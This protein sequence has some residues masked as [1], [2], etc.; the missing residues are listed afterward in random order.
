MRSRFEDLTKKI[1]QEFGEVSSKGS[2]VNVPSYLKPVSDKDEAKKQYW[3]VDKIRSDIRYLKLSVERRLSEIQ[4]LIKNPD[5]IRKLLTTSD[6]TFSEALGKGIIEAAFNVS[7][8]GVNWSIDARIKHATWEL[9][10]LYKSNKDLPSKF[11]APIK[12]LDNLLKP[13]ESQL[14]WH[15]KSPLTD[16]AAKVAG[17]VWS[18]GASLLSK[19]DNNKS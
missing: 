5:E 15:E 1:S 6:E 3:E 7:N 8:E 4:A 13:L 17:A 19:K 16:G 11:D 10:R 2:T 12:Q 14:E 18:F 9:E